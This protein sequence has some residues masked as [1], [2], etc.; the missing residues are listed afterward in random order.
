MT[1]NPHGALRASVP[2]VPTARLH[3]GVLSDF[4]SV[5]D[6]R[7]CRGFVITRGRSGFEAF[8]SDQCS[9]GT[10]PTQREAANT[11]MERA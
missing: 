3:R 2:D 5:Y 4:L 9:L 11:I 7:I 8:D 1:L 6:G 10:Y